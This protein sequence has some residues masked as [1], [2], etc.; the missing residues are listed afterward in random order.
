MFDVI[1]SW[2]DVIW[3]PIVYFG[4]YKQHRWWSIGLILFSMTLIRLLAE[5][6]TYSGYNNGIMGFLEANVHTRGIIVSSFFYILF[7]I[8]SYYS[9]DTKG[10]AFMAACLS[11]FFMIF[12]SS[13]IAMIL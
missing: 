10:A 12:V 1:Y 8:L 13:S 5:I 2:I 11:I 9:K 3:L 7:M 6:M 4:A